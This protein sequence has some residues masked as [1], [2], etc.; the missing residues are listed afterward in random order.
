MAWIFQK[1]CGS[2][3]QNDGV[4]EQWLPGFC[5][6]IRLAREKKFAKVLY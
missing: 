6:L 5:N 3:G 2:N 1:K 4:G